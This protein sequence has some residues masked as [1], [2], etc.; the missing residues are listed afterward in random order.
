MTPLELAEALLSDAVL[1]LYAS[2][3]GDTMPEYFVR[4]MAKYKMIRGIQDPKT[5]EKSV[6]GFRGVKPLLAS[7]P[8]VP[9][10]FPSIRLALQ[11]LEKVPVPR[12]LDLSEARIADAVI[13]LCKFDIKVAKDYV[14]NSAQKFMEACLRRLR[15]EESPEQRAALVAEANKWRRPED[16]LTWEQIVT[17][18]PVG[19]NKAKSRNSKP[20]KA[21]GPPD[22]KIKQRRAVVA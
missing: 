13:V 22:K 20:R 4:D 2:A 16:A 11:S 7:R 8:A 10:T 9:M 19:P 15:E 12:L 17:A 3:P 1:H 14:N 21:A 6:H 5:L 18:L